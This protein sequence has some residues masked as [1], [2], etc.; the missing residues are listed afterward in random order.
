MELSN[1]YDQVLRTLK[2]KNDEVEYRKVQIKEQMEQLIR[3]MKRLKQNSDEVEAL[4]YQMLQQTLA[5]LKQ[6]YEENANIL[7]NDFSEL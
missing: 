5:M 1:A 6:K 4:I 3:Q 2:G 7:K